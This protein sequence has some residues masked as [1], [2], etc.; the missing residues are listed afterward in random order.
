MMQYEK[1]MGA[2]DIEQFER[3]RQ[4]EQNLNDAL[5]AFAALEESFEKYQQVQS[6]IAELE[7][8]YGSKLWWEDYKADE[9]GW[10]PKD[11]KRG[12]LSEDAVYN[13]LTENER[14][15][16]LLKLCYNSDTGR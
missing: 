13:L 3:I 5:S 12:V 11:L 8:Y 1:G 4:M 16:R 7:K 10:L 2:A 6:K 15:Q 9:A 14:V